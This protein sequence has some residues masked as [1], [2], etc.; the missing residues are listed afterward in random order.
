M[1]ALVSLGDAVE[2]QDVADPGPKAGEVLVKVAAC[3]I[4]GSDVHSVEHGAARVGQILGHELAGTIAAVGDGVGG[5]QV[6]QRVAVNPL[7]ACGSCDWCQREVSIRCRNVPNIGLNAPGGYAELVAV[8]APQLVALPDAMTFAQGAHVEPL[9][10]ALRSVREA[11]LT[12]GERVIVFGAGPIGLNTVLAA[13]ACG[14]GQV[15]VVE[16]EERRRAAAL[17]IGADAAVT[18]PELTAA[19]NLTEHRFDAGFECAGAPAALRACIESVREA[20]RIVQVAL[21]RIDSALPTRLFVVKN[22]RLLSSTA[23]GPRE[24]AQAFE[25]IASGAVDIEPLI[26]DRISLDEAPAAFVRLRRP[27][28]AVGVIVQPCST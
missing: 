1:R 26:T 23:F 14:A 24:Y 22:Q 4:C 16:P 8:P 13:R 28:G 3:G 9:A 5:W 2:V 7:G 19:P 25:L 17:R 27:E 6:G 10:V 12:S 15:V 11:D 20:G 21:G 18:P